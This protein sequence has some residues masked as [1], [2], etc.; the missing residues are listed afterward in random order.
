MV[1]TGTVACLGAG[2]APPRYADGYGVGV[3]NSI[4]SAY[5]R[6][7]AARI[8]RSDLPWSS[9]R[10][11]SRVTPRQMPQVGAIESRTTLPSAFTCLT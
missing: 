2:V 8:A 5:L 9:M 3:E 7:I 4:L 11:T 10:I 1:D 6:S